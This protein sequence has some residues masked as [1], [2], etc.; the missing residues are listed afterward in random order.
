MSYIVWQGYRLEVKRCKRHQMDYVPE[1]GV[2]CSEC[3]REEDDELERSRWND[4]LSISL[5]EE[6]DQGHWQFLYS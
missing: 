5:L 6:E 1:F 3:E 2:G 4:P